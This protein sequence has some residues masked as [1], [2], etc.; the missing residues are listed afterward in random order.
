MSLD[1]T[2][3]QDLFAKAVATVA[4]AA[5]KS[6]T[7]PQLA[8]VLIATD[9]GRV[10]LT[11]TDLEMS[12][13][14][15]FDCAITGEGACTVDA[16]FLSGVLGALPPSLITVHLD[17]NRLRLLCGR[18]DAEMLTLDAAD[19]P[20]LAKPDEETFSIDGPSLRSCL[21][22]VADFA[23]TDSTRAVLTCVN[24]RAVAGRLHA[25]A[26]DGFRFGTIS[27][28]APLAPDFD[29]L[30]PAGAAKEMARAFASEETVGVAVHERRLTCYTADLRI[31]ST[32]VQGAYPDFAKTAP[33]SFAWTA[34]VDA[35]ELK[36]HLQLARLYA[37]DKSAFV[38]V[39]ASP[40]GAIEVSGETDGRG[41]GALDGQVTIHGA[42]PAHLRFA[43]QPG[44]L[45]DAIAN[46][47]GVAVLDIAAA[48]ACLVHPA[49]E[50]SDFRCLVMLLM[51]KWDDQPLTEQQLAAAQAAAPGGDTDEY[52]E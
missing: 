45:A 52:R 46:I 14:T 26:A 51:A 2:V 16:A 20:A 9:G 10:R 3:S 12:I 50:A 8:H 7:M 49:N 39:V 11:C 28:A 15:A 48:N 4:R 47:E 13:S 41:R 43:I 22:A 34:A 5:S 30:L 37:R 42:P 32:L 17:G 25:A 19:F 21:E 18:Q 23:G 29:L 40:D 24:L 36:R 38:R 35:G 33:K 1:F 31:T 27:V 6:S 44:F